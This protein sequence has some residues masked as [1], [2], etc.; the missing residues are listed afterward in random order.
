MTNEELLQSTLNATIER[1][2]KQT[3]SYESEI[4]NLNAQ[5]IFLNNRLNELS[6]EHL[7]DAD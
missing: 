4:A 1:M 2:G 5:I 3:T 7:T 6:R